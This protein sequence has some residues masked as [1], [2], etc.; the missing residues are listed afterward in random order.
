MRCDFFSLKRKNEKYS[1]HLQVFRSALLMH[2]L[3]NYNL[4]FHMFVFSF[5][6]IIKFKCGRSREVLIKPSFTW[7]ITL[8]SSGMLSNYYLFIFNYLLNLKKNLL[9]I[10]IMFLSHY[11]SF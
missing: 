8:L 5:P 3:F 1:I 10:L 7:I 2:D 6:T 11:A 4:F 9:W